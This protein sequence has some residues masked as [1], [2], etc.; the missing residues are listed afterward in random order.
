MKKLQILA[1]MMAVLTL[2]GCLV[3]CGGAEETETETEVVTETEAE[4][5]NE[6]LDEW[7][8][9]IVEDGVPTDLSFANANDNTITFFTRDAK[10]YNTEMDCDIISDD[11]LNDSIYYRNATVEERLGVTITQI[12]QAWDWS[13]WSQ[14]LRNSVLNKTGDFD[15]A[16]IYASQ[17][18][19]LATEGIYLNLNNLNYIDTAKPWW[20]QKA[21]DELEL[22][23]AL[24]FLNGDVVVSQL[25]NAG[26]IVYNKNLFS[27]YYND[28]N[29]YELVDNYEWTIDKLYELSKN[30][31]V[32]MNM[33]AKADDG[34]LLG[35]THWTFDA[36]G[37]Y[38]DLWM[39]AL[40]VAMTTKDS[41]GIPQISIYNDRSILAFEKLQNLCTNNPAC[42]KASGLSITTFANSMVM[43]NTADLRSCEGLRDMKDEY[44][45]LPL[46]ML[47]ES[48]G[49]YAT[50]SQNACS[51]VV[52]CSDLPAEKWDMMGATLELMA[53]ES[54]R[55]VIPKYMEVCLRSKYSESPDD[56]RMYDLIVD[57]ITID[58]GFVYASKSIATINGLFRNLYN[59]F[60]QLYTSKQSS[61]ESAL[62]ALID[63]LDE[64]SYQ[65]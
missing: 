7:G 20:N 61:Y 65:N 10:P 34:D 30:V 50:Y 17:C 49:Y 51:L 52:V 22:F 29:L 58:F 63:K 3:A 11:T 6:N 25:L 55:Q 46:P 31:H 59:D 26:I 53:A 35:L 14:Q 12:S 16:A 40:G 36:D 1:L 4:T 24:Y 18:S 44:G 45:A 56:A 64:I 13:A 39:A 37:G 54:Y 21:V 33:S 60:A 47:D 48:Q 62:T 57:G 23:G 5:E 8:R 32:D 27:Q 2:L 28:I 19:A 15:A 38:M 9:E 42:L 43:F 41:D